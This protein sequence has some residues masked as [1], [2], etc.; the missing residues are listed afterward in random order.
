MSHGSARPVIGITGRR[1]EASA[2][3]VGGVGLA[4]QAVDLFFNDYVKSIV[5]AGGTA[6]GLSRDVPAEHLIDALDGLVLCGG[7]DIDPARYGHDEADGL[8]P[9]DKG[10]DEFELALYAAARVRGMPVL[11][12]CRGFQLINVANGGTLRQHVDRDEGSGHPNFFE[13]GS[14]I[15]HAVQT[16]PG[17]LIADLVGAELG[18]NSLHHQTVLEVGRDV[19][20]TASAPDG[21]AEALEADDGTTLAVQWHPEMLT[22]PDPTFVWLVSAA[23]AYRS[24]ATASDVLDRTPRRRGGE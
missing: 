16:V 17:S 8:G 2:L 20:I 14:T 18:V 9:L 23:T 19:R 22:Q 3:K 11:G 24:V 21:V 15:R 10:R 6:V 4:H 5:A 7:A 13:P 12:V 1:A